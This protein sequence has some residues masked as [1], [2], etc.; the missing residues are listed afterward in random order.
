MTI[1]EA[2]EK[3]DFQSGMVGAILNFPGG[4]SENQAFKKSDLQRLANGTRI[5][6]P[7]DG[8]P[9]LAG[10]CT[11]QKNRRIVKI[12]MVKAWMT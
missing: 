9:Y 1:D 3:L 4:Y 8:K 11:I 5:K 2:I 12:K 7:Q 6:N 10:N